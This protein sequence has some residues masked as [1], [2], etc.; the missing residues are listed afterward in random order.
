VAAAGIN[1]PIN[2]PPASSRKN[3][4]NALEIPKWLM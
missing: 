3:R 2:N 1:P 4:K